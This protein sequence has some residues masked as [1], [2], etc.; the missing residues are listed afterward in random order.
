MLKFS[1]ILFFLLFCFS[2]THFPQVEKKHYR[3]GFYVENSYGRE[4]EIEASQNIIPVKRKAVTATTGRKDS[5][6]PFFTMP[7]TGGLVR[8]QKPGKQTIIA[9]EKKHPVILSPPIDLPKKEPM[10]KKVKAGIAFYILAA[11]TLTA[12]FIL[13]LCSLLN[14]F[15]LLAG[16]AAFFALLALLFGILAKR[17]IAGETLVTKERGEKEAQQVITR[18]VA[19]LAGYG[20]LLLLAILVNWIARR[21]GW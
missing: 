9:S 17:E 6:Q 18:S 16:I 2:C 3:K 20:F 14:L 19:G 10:N 12:S 4:K 5:T 15:F 21:S 7:A 1:W 13:L 11:L 8:Q